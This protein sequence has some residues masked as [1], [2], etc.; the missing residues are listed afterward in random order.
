MISGFGAVLDLGQRLQTAARHIRW[1]VVWAAVWAAVRTRHIQR[2]MVLRVAE[3]VWSEGRSSIM[4]PLPT[5]VATPLP[6]MPSFSSHLHTLHATV[7]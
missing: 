2:W 7:G 5:T 6:P 1:M 3:Q 4:A